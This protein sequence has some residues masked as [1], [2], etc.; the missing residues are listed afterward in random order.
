VFS[1]RSWMKPE[2][3]QRE[4]SVVERPSAAGRSGIFRRGMPTRELFLV[5]LSFWAVVV[6]IV[7]LVAFVLWGLATHGP[8]QTPL[9]SG[10]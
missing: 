9:D 8:S 2:S 7:L 1:I 6:A 3:A 4:T 5:K 10:D